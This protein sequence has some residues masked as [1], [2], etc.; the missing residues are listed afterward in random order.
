MPS[1]TELR[2]RLYDDAA[3]SG[4]VD[5]LTLLAPDSEPSM[6]GILALKAQQRMIDW[7]KVSL[8]SPS[9]KPVGAASDI[10]DA[11]GTFV[12]EYRLL[13]SDAKGAT[14]W[15]GMP[16]DVV[17]I[18]SDGKSVVVF[19]SKIGSEVGYE[20]DSPATNQFARQMDFLISLAGSHIERVAYVLISTRYMLEKEWYPQLEA[21]LD[22]SGR[23]AVL[24][25]FTV[26]WEE[27]ISATTA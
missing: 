1:P 26:I 11:D 7:G 16:C 17:H 2:R 10:I 6:S 14:T 8:N 20:S 4:F 22:Y 9:F 15:Q 25:A 12:A 24:P 3:K 13:H 21:S 18:G 5:P 27:V 19:E 23:R